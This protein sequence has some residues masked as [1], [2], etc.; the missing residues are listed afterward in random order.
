MPLGA[1]YIGSYE[2]LA[3]RFIKGAVPIPTL[4]RFSNFIQ[5]GVTLSEHL[6]LPRKTGKILSY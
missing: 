3:Q 4:D 2:Y 1:Q 6:S 5:K